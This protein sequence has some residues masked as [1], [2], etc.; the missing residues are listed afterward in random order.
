MPSPWTCGML[1]IVKAKN[2][3]IDGSWLVDGWHGSTDIV[4]LWREEDGS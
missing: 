4:H 3:R 2:S 1:A